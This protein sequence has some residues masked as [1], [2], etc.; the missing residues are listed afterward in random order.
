M[1]RGSTRLRIL[2]RV[3]QF[4]SR[5]DRETGNPLGERRPEC[6]YRRRSSPTTF[7]GQIAQ[8][9]PGRAAHIGLPPLALEAGAPELEWRARL[10]L[11]HDAAK[12]SLHQRAQRDPLALGKLTSFT[13]KR[14]RN[15]YGCL[16]DPYVWD[17]RYGRPYCTMRQSEEQTR[18]GLA[19]PVNGNCV[20]PASLRR[21]SLAPAAR[22]AGRA[23][24]PSEAAERS[25]CLAAF[26]SRSVPSGA[27]RRRAQE[28]RS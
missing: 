14:I 12:P 26:G 20:P 1:A 22:R 7:V 5:L 19:L 11:R 17:M 27:P 21:R 9:A 4:A 3:P 23:G 15:F 10:G 18:A 28:R 24:R 25:D 8:P 6:S 13:K 16:H 2:R